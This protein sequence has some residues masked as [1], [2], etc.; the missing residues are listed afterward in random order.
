[1]RKLGI[2]FLSV[3]LSSA[4]FA[5]QE[6]LSP[7]Q[8][9]QQFIQQMV[10]QDHFNRA[11][12]THLFSTLHK[13]PKII[14]S[15]TAP[16]EKQSWSHYRDYFITPERITLGAKYLTD[17][18]AILLKMQKEYGIPA[19]IIVAIIGVETKYGM[20]LG[21]HSV[22]NT[23][24]T[25][26]FYYPPREKFFKKELAQ[27]LI[28]TRDE[29][30]PVTKL[31]GSYAGALGIPQFMPS[32][33]RHFGVSTEKNGRVNLFANNDAIASVANYFHKNGWKPN[34]PIAHHLRSASD[35]DA[36]RISLPL[37]K[38]TDYWEVYHNFNVIMSYNHN[39]VYAMV[40]YQLSK[41]IEKQY[42]KNR[43]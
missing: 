24:Y 10:S 4:V 28:L 7:K 33:Y 32:S 30:L 38:G 19:S 5:N 21:A 23:L 14:A 9:K 25:L 34:Q 43:S 12:L 13:D 16:F 20:H 3:A 35:R 17:H 27:Y 1:M 18:H 15:V 31:R 37:K 40:V 42:A 6:S 22:L 36:K 8:N 11:Q 41:M 29:H 2:L 26:G 39:V